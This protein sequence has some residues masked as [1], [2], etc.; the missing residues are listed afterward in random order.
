MPSPSAALEE[1]EEEEEEEG[2][3]KADTV[4]EEEGALYIYIY[5][6]WLHYEAR[7]EPRHRNAKQFVAIEENDDGYISY[8]E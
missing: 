5:R 4:K 3:F 1:E 8:A 7:G 2:L 6:Q